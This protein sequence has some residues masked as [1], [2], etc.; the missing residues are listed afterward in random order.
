MS[1]GASNSSDAV[2][3]EKL[4]C[5][6]AESRRVLVVRVVAGAGTGAAAATKKD[7]GVGGN[8]RNGSAKDV[9]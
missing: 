7:D 6:Y 9:R 5:D 2:L 4:A 1:G 3:Q 8:S